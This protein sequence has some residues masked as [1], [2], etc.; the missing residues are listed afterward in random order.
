MLINQSNQCSLSASMACEESGKSVFTDTE[1]GNKNFGVKSEKKEH[2]IRTV[3]LQTTNNCTALDHS[4][5]FTM[6]IFDFIQDFMLKHS[7][8]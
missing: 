5:L 8:Q 1:T 3:E 4:M 2:F 6:Y 7:M